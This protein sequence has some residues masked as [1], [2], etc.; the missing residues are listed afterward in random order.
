VRNQIAGSPSRDRGVTGGMFPSPENL[1]PAA[2]LGQVMGPYTGRKRCCRVRLNAALTVGLG[3]V[4]VGAGSGRVGF[5]SGVGPCGARMASAHAK[6]RRMVRGGQPPSESYTR[7]ARPCRR[8]ADPEW[9]D[10]LSDDVEAC[11]SLITGRLA[12]LQV[13][14]VRVRL[15]VAGALAETEG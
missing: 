11:P 1:I 12:A 8:T 7:R 9:V 5:N 10:E 6:A 3:R 14:L 13:A 2:E 4:R 15:D